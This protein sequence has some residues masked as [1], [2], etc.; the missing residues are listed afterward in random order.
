MLA[1]LRSGAPVRAT[2]RA[3]P[4]L[5][6]ERG[7]A[8]SRLPSLSAQPRRGECR[9]PGARRGAWPRRVRTSGAAPRSAPRCGPPLR[10]AGLGGARPP[11]RRGAGLSRRLSAPRLFAAGLPRDGFN[12][13]FYS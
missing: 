12:G 3:L 4:P 7:A 6:P 2:G 1:P 13:V 5:C 9:G 11:G 10:A 8:A